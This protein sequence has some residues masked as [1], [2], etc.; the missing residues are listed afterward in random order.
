MKSLLISGL[1][2]VLV[3]SLLLTFQTSLS[4]EEAKLEVKGTPW[5]LV[6]IGDKEF[7]G[8]EGAP[9]PFIKLLPEKNRVIGFTGCNKFGGTYTL[10][11]SKVSFDLKLSTKNACPKTPGMDTDFLGTLA[12]AQTFK[13]QGSKLELMADGKV[14]AEFSELKMKK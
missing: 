4:A 1:K 2:A 14:I 13:S 7:K 3:F 8:T 10:E 12:K 11:G 6:K 5:K 9:P